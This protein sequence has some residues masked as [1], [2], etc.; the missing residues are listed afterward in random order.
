MA[1][2]YA[3]VGIDG[4]R[5]NWGWAF[6]LGIALIVLG[7]IALGASMFTTVASVL[8]FGWLLIVGGALELAHGFV[9]RAWS[10]FFLDV[11]SGVLYLVVGF[12]F[13]SNPLEA[14]VT[15]TLMLALA[16]I[17]VGIMRIVVAV[18]SGFQHWVWLLLNGI[19][20]LVLGV[21]IWRQWPESGLW[22]IGLFIGIDMIFYGWALVMLA[23]GVR[24]LPAET[25]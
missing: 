1:T 9:R 3:M 25:A 6:A 2:G 21:L 20:T 22:V 14:A 18:S 5:R 19:I 23:I 13:V 17:F 16:L 15:L 4:L 11:L 8:M 7:M 10:G 12:L 24:S